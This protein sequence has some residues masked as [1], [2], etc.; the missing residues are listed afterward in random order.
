MRKSV[1]AVGLVSILGACGGGG[2]GGGSVGPIVPPEPPVEPNGHSSTVGLSRDADGNIS[3][4]TFR[5]V[6]EN[7][8]SLNDDDQLLNNGEVIAEDVAFLAELEHSN[9][10]M[11]TRD[12]GKRPSVTV[13]AFGDITPSDGLPL[14]DARYEG[15]STGIVQNNV[16]GVTDTTVSTMTVEVTNGF[17]DIAIESSDT[18]FTDINNTGQDNLPRNYDF[19]GQ[20]KISGTGF[21]TQVVNAPGE[22]NIS[23]RV[24]GNFYGPNA[25]EVGGVFKL[26]GSEKSTYLGSFGA[27]R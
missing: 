11:W 8:L 4:V 17:R 15:Q 22:L 5:G 10:G 12:T 13:A 9:F 3:A 26:T 1:L 20:G 16:L 19:K 14:E 21:T 6:E 18:R 7:L 25:E 23:G 2:G 24:M 27:A